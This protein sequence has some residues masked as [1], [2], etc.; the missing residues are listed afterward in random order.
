MAANAS[1]GPRR[2]KTA[3]VLMMLVACGAAR[4][5]VY[6]VV[7]G[8]QRLTLTCEGTAVV[9]TPC[10]IASGPGEAMPLRFTTKPTRYVHLLKPALDKA[11]ASNKAPLPLDRAD[12]S[13]LR[14]LALDK[15]HPDADYF[16]DLFQLCVPADSDSSIVLFVRGLCDRCEFEPIILKRQ[17]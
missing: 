16:G 13:L 9:E 12:V 15:C 1:S 11:I 7:S 14:G 6:A 2:V 10:K 5:D 4:A 8:D 17:K 3:A